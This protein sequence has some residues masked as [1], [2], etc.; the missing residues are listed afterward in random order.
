[1]MKNLRRK[2]WCIMRVTQRLRNLFKW[3]K[4][5][6][7]SQD[8]ETIIAHEEKKKKKK[9]KKQ[10]LPVRKGPTTRTHSSVVQE[11]EPDFK[12]SSDEEEK[13]LLKEADDDGYEPLS[14]MLQK[15]RKSRAKQRP[16]RK[17]Y[18]EKMEA[19]HEQLCLK[20]CFKEQHQF[21]EA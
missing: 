18:N 21:R 15:K 7:V 20:M 12:P 3:M 10:K 2:K 6:V 4:M 13:G 1:M 17:W 19:P 8:E 14:F 11:E 16:P 9:K 5:I